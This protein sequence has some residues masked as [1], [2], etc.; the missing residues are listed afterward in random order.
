[1]DSA[2][3]LKNLNC[4]YAGTCSGC[5]L[6]ALS[7]SEQ[8]KLKKNDLVRAWQDASVGAELPKI[9]FVSISNGGLRDRADFILDRRSGSTA[10]GLFNTS[11]EIM[12]LEN[13]AQLSPALQKWLTE[14]RATLPNVNRGSFRIRVSPSGEKGIW[15]DLANLDVKTLL[16]EKAQLLK[17][18]NLG[19][20]EI[21]QKRKKLI[22]RDGELKLGDPELK[23]WFETYIGESERP[24]PLFTT[25]GGFTQPGFQANRVLIRE[26]RLAL[27]KLDFS[28]VVEFGS[29]S[30]NLTLPFAAQA[31]SVE[32]YELD[33]LAC[34][35][36]KKG[37]AAAG[38]SQKVKINTGNFQLE[39]NA[40]KFSGIDLVVVD[41]PRSG[42][43]GFLAN[44]KTIQQSDRPRAFLYIS[45]FADSFSKDAAELVQLGY[46][47]DQVTIV[48]QFPQSPHYEIIA[49]FKNQV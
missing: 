15:L 12:D 25:V 33:T 7:Y 36:L 31:D 19:F 37:L 35:G 38:L 28:H 10:F 43:M 5:S 2:I 26:I 39:K 3:E 17:L 29:G 34:E 46:K 6:I 14:V 21:G 27:K 44:F 18:Q 8:T 49:L 9:K 40:P 11:R 4:I 1:M 48:D 42:L 24:V 20:V 32:A 41:P 30:G 16:D 22:T 23:S 47:P 13:C 45:C